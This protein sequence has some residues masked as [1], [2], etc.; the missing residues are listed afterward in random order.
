[1]GGVK[2]KYMK[3]LTAYC[4]K[5]KEKRQLNPYQA[6][7]HETKGG[8]KMIKDKCSTCGT[9]LCRMTSESDI[10]EFFEDV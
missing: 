6:E 7:V 3:K 5:C 9:T 2:S 10:K 4:V 8:N 1:M